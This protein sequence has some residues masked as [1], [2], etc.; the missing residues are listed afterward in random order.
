[1]SQKVSEKDMDLLAGMLYS[2]R[3]RCDR[4]SL[5]QQPECTDHLQGL[6]GGA[7]FGWVL[8]DTVTA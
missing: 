8:E 1:M 5:S 6:S 4:F 3:E 7:S 2:R